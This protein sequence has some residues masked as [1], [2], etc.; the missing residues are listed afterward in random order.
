MAQRRRNIDDA[1]RVSKKQIRMVSGAVLGIGLLVVAWAY[2][3]SGDRAQ[4]TELRGV[5]PGDASQVV[6]DR[7]GAPP[8]NCQVGTLEHLRTEFPDDYAPAAVDEALERIRE[9]TAQRW[10][11]PTG[12]DQARCTARGGDAEVGLGQNGKVLWLVRS[13]GRT[14]LELLDAFHPAT[15]P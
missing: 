7:V 14:P 4:R 1:L 6:V 15:S 10:V 5:Q 9:A 3:A 12:G 11:Y 13:M 2:F 8:A